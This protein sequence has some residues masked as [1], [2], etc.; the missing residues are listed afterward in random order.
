MCIRDRACIKTDG[1]E[2]K[3]VLQDTKLVFFSV[4]GNDLYYILQEEDPS[5]AN[6][7]QNAATQQQQQNTIFNLYNK[8]VDSDKAT[9]ISKSNMGIY[10]VYKDRIYY[11][12][13]EEQALSLIHI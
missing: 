9:K 8:K 2:T 12:N 11:L 10:T 13:N 3:T 7:Q 4:V 1:S 5:A 6:T